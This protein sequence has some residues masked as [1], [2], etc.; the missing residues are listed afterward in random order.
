MRPRFVLIGLFLTIFMLALTGRIQGFEAD[1][2]IHIRLDGLVDP[3]SAP[4]ATQDN[5]TYVMTDNVYTTVSIE[6]DNVVFNGA[7]HSVLG[8]SA[9]GT[10]GIELNGRT[11][12]TIMNTSVGEFWEGIYISSS[13]D[14]NVSGNFVTDHYDGIVVMSSTGCTVTGNNVT[15]NYDDAIYF[16]NCTNLTASGNQIRGSDLTNHDYGATVYLSSSGTIRGNRIFDIEF[17]IGIQN[18]EKIEVSENDVSTVNQYAL[19]L[20][21]SSNITLWENNVINNSIGVWLSSS[22][23]NL[24]YRNN[25]VNNSVQVEAGGT[26]NDWNGTYSRAGNYWSDYSNKDFCGGQSQNQTGSDGIGDKPYVIDQKNQDNYP[27]MQPIPEYSSIM[28]AAV[29]MM[30]TALI[31]FCRRSIQDIR[32][33]RSNAEDTWS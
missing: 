2:A 24:F 33:T 12:V 27:L 14:I 15:L 22:P 7:N 29:F 32:K 8:S 6:R 30:S 3:S 18:S 13:S 4:I 21:S 25:F 23:N 9:F 20:A 17:G 11:N 26:V 28:I 10:N 31:V 5:A 16:E 19:W 1:Q